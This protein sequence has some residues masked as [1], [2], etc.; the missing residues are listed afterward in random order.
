MSDENDNIEIDS[1]EVEFGAMSAISLI[2]DNGQVNV[3]LGNV[4]PVAAITVLEHVADALRSSL[5]PPSV[6]YLGEP[7]LHY[8]YIDEEGE[9]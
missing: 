6:Q 3:D 7:I 4:P 2:I 8:Y 1:L 9:D 5:V